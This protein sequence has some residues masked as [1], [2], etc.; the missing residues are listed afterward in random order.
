MPVEFAPPRYAQMVNT[1]QERITAGTYPP[2]STLPSE[3]Q[4]IAEFGVSRT[5]VTRALNL[6]RQ[7]G[8]I[9]SQ[10]GLGT[11]V[12][13]RP[14]TSTAPRRGQA[15]IGQR[16]AESAVH[17]LDAGTGRPPARV[18]AALGLD[19][20]DETVYRRW[21]G[22]DPDGTPSELVT[23]WFPP[24][25]VTGTLLDS[26]DLIEEGVREHLRA[27]KKLRL[28]HLTERVSARLATAEESRALAMPRRG[29]VLSVLVIARD[30]GGGIVE[31]VDAVLPAD[32]HELEDTYPTT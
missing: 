28:D 7:E 23:A 18:A 1:I 8:W 25:V 26:V 30:A 24:E 4:L 17:L 16:E 14:P 13:S 27:R 31:V 11:F 10:Q 32:R 3:N 29:V 2:G 21:V 6:L 12:R 22:A 15:L 5:T 20:G 19:E 9:N